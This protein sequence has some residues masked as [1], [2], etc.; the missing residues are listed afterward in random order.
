MFVFFFILLFC[1]SNL[2]L[3]VRKKGWV[4]DNKSI[5]ITKFTRQ[6]C[7]IGSYRTEKWVRKVA[8]KDEAV[9]D[10]KPV[11]TSNNTLVRDY[12]SR[13][14][15]SKSGRTQ[16]WATTSTTVQNNTKG[17]EEEEPEAQQDEEEEEEEQPNDDA[18]SVTS[19]DTNAME[20]D[21]TSNGGEQDNNGQADGNGLDD[22]L[23]ED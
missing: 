18:K 5:P 21:E 16:S 8:I 4:Q 13:R 19:I 17:E 15:A 11:Y 12:N 1:C 2:S 14:R 23:E 22:L 20:D 7:T 9:P 3:T 10:T 6:N